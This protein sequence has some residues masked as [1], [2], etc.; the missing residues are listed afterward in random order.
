MTKT[1]LEKVAE[2]AKFLGIENLYKKCL[3]IQMSNDKVSPNNCL[4][5]WGVATDISDSKLARKAKPMAIK[6]FVFLQHSP[7]FQALPG[8]CVQEYL[9]MACRKGQNYI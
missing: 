4:R 8:K 6:H 9:T 2:L 5:I 3:G 7:D 1:A